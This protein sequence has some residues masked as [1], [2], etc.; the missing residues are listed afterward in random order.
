MVNAPTG[1]GNGH[2]CAARVNGDLV[3]EFLQ[4]LFR[5]DRCTPALN[6]V[7]K[8][9]R[10]GEPGAEFC[11]LV[12]RFRRFD[13]QHV[14]A[15]L[16]KGFSAAQSFVQAVGRAR[17]GAG[18]DQE[19]ATVA[20]LHRHPN[21]AHH[22]FDRHHSSAERV[23][24]PFRVFL[25]LDLNRGRAGVLIALDRVVGVDQAAEAG[26]GVGDQRCRRA[27]GHVEGC[28]A[29]TVGRQGG[30][31]VEHAGGDDEFAGIKA[32]AQGCCGHGAKLLQ[33]IAVGPHYSG[34]YR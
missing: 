29:H 6:D 23:A 4:A 32:G 34:S 16:G 24:A 12:F 20:R 2:E 11:H 9:R 15:G 1:G 18:D 30:D 14:G 3:A 7:G 8:Q 5:Q 33:R 25:V 27:A 13:E 31:H 21:L 22:F 28:E 10:S 26:V 19:V 17:V